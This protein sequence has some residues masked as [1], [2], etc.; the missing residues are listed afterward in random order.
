MLAH[1][2]HVGRSI[3]LSRCHTLPDRPEWDSETKRLP[4]EH[5]KTISA[6]DGVTWG[7]GCMQDA[8]DDTAAEADVHTTDTNTQ[9]GK[10]ESKEA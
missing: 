5:R 8:R 7:Q 2:C 3:S 1:L 4:L 10:S 9:T 6:A